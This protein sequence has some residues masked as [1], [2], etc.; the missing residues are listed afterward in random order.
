MRRKFLAIQRITVC[1]VY[2]VYVGTIYLLKVQNVIPLAPKYSERKA[3][4][5]SH[6]IKLHG[7]HSAGG[8]LGCK[9][10]RRTERSRLWSR[11]TCFSLCSTFR[12]VHLPSLCTNFL[13]ILLHI[14]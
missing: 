13:S 5:V 7:E 4:L 12:P 2:H 8:F 9:G 6:G 1:F 14:S 11:F 3:F 10:G